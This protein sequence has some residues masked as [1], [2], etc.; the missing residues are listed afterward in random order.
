MAFMVHRTTYFPTHMTW[1]LGVLFCTVR[2]DRILFSIHNITSIQDC[3]TLSYWIIVLCAQSLVLL[4]GFSQCVST[5]NLDLNLISFQMLIRK[6]GSMM[7]G[8]ESLRVLLN[9]KLGSGS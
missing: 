1:E 8:R 5:V 7:P 6:M 4:F 9:E 2:K 3:S